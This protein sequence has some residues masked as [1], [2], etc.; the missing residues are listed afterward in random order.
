MAAKKGAPETGAGESSLGSSD[1]LIMRF[2][3]VELVR[4][5]RSVSGAFNILEFGQDDEDND[6]ICFQLSSFNCQA[7]IV[8]QTRNGNKPHCSDHVLTWI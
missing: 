4:M 8:E 2:V 3:Y 1:S 5:D 7:W 6:S